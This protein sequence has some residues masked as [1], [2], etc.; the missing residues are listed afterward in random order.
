[1]VRP[2]NVRLDANGE[3]IFM[4]NLKN[5][6]GSVNLEKDSDQITSLVSHLTKWLSCRI[7]EVMLK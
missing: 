3:I 5:K 7:V 4:K 1:M 2:Q 6:G